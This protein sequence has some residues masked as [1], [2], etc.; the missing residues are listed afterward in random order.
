M[1]TGFQSSSATQVARQ[2]TKLNAVMNYKRVSGNSDVT[3]AITTIAT[4]NK[5]P[6]P[7]KGSSRVLPQLST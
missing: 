1:Q 5:L 2:S 7:Q 6:F 4:N 3:A